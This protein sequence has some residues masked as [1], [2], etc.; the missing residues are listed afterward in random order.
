MTFK[1]QF[2]PVFKTR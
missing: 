2:D 1:C